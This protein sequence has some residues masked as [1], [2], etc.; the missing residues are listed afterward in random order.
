VLS[1]QQ[2]AD[3]GSEWGQLYMSEELAELQARYDT[4]AVRLQKARVEH[5]PGN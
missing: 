4:Q 3:S 5:L 2:T 1:P